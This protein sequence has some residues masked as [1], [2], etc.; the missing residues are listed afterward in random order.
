MKGKNMCKLCYVQSLYVFYEHVAYE[1]QHLVHCGSVGLYAQILRRHRQESMCS[2][3]AWANTWDPVSKWKSKLEREGMD[4]VVEC[5]PSV[6]ECL[7]SMDEALG[8][9]PSTEKKKRKATF[10]YK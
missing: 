8:S 4:Q 1:R 6:V 5:L 9:I 3:T 2:R 10:Y 7:P